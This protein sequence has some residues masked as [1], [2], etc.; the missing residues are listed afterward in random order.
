M[1]VIYLNEK[2]PKVL[3]HEVATSIVCSIKLL[4][5]NKRLEKVAEERENIFF[6][7]K[8][9]NTCI[10]HVEEEL[11]ILIDYKV[12]VYNEPDVECSLPSLLSAAHYGV[13]Q[14]INTPGGNRDWVKNSA[15]SQLIGHDIKRLLHG[16]G[17]KIA[18]M[19]LEHLSWTLD[20]RESYKEFGPNKERDSHRVRIEIFNM[21]EL[22]WLIDKIIESE[23]SKTP[24]EW[25]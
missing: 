19:Q 10:M 13:Y 18:G 11:C 16:P 24:I 21:E 6:H 7:V 4:E 25:N 2:E 20:E 8:E 14:T 3:V 17:C 22:D 5:E 9:T 15:T 23:Q 1:G 12:R